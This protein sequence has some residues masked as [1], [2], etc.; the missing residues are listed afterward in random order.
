MRRGRGSM[1]GVSSVSSWET[2]FPVAGAREIPSTPCPAA[3]I[4]LSQECGLPIEG[5]P[6]GV[7]G[8][9]PC[10]IS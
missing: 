6:S 1:N 8:L 7:Q 3:T 5:S 4:T 2:S 10:Q 9:S